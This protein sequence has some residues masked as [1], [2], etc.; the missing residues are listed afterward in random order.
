MLGLTVHDPR[1]SN[2]RK[3]E[4]RIN[5]ISE[6]D[7]QLINNICNLWPENV[8]QSNIWDSKLRENLKNNKCS[9]DSLNKRRSEVSII[10]SIKYII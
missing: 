6:N 1:L 10:K 7:Q 3:M 8:A 5:E 2:F 9:E 4:K